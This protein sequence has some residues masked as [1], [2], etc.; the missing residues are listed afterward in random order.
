ML[1]AGSA[2]GEELSCQSDEYIAGEHEGV[3]LVMSN[4][5]ADYL[6]VVLDGAPYFRASKVTRLEG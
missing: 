4:K 2:D 1:G 6:I 3:T 5:F